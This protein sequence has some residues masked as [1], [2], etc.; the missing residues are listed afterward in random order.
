MKHSITFLLQVKNEEA[1]DSC[2]LA[3]PTYVM[4]KVD[5]QVCEDPEVTITTNTEREDLKVKA[6]DDGK[7]IVDAV[8]VA[9]VKN[10]KSRLILVNIYM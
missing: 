4:I 9:I 1:L 10:H 5:P 6:D 7:Y 8:V 2:K 3:E